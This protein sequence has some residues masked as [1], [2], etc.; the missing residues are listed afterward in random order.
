MPSPSSEPARVSLSEDLTIRG[1]A[2]AHASLSAAFAEGRDVV[3]EIDGAAPADLTLA[4]LIESARRTAAELD[5]GFSLAAP[6]QGD[7]VEVLRRGGFL[8]TAE[9][10]AFWLTPLE[11]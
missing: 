3:A 4:Q 6:P 9:R 10:E 8:D 2:Q 11:R 5:L 1:I 7:L